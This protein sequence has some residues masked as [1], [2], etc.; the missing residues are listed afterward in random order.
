MNFLARLVEK[1]Y[2]SATTKDESH[3]SWRFFLR[4]NGK[5]MISCGILRDSMDSINREYPLLVVGSG[6]LPG[7]E[8]KWDEMF[9]WFA[10]VFSKVEYFLS[11]KIS[12]L[13][14]LKTGISKLGEPAISPSTAGNEISRPV[15]DEKNGFI[16]LHE[17]DES[18]LAAQI[19]NYLTRLKKYSPSPPLAVFV[20]GKSDETKLCVFRERLDSSDIAKLWKHE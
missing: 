4:G 12:S 3:H 17:G 18:E 5:G 7:W 15:Q 6:M 2:G 1:G 19:F 16:T 9:T 13:D 8:G 20:G 14:E 10:P 11:R